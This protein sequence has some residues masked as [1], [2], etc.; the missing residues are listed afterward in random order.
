[1]KKLTTE[2]HEI[3]NDYFKT[4]F[5][6]IKDDNEI[7]DEIHKEKFLDLISSLNKVSQDSEVDHE[8]IDWNSFAD[9]VIGF[10][11]IKVFAEIR[12]NFP[13]FYK[14]IEEKMGGGIGGGYG[15]LAN[16]GF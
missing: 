3:I 14:I 5:E 4:L 6:K 16:F 10:N 8:Q 1:M 11:E 13:E 7:K 12:K 2:G 15:M 9:A